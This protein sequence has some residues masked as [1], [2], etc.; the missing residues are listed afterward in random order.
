MSV[1]GTAVLLTTA[2]FAPFIYHNY[3]AYT[4]FCKS[5]TDV[6][7]SWC[8]NALPC[9]YTYSQSRYWNVGFLRY[10]SFSQIPN[11]IVAA[12]LF[13]LIADFVTA[14]AQYH[15]LFSSKN[16]IATDRAPIAFYNI[17]LLPHLIH[18][19]ILFCILLLTAHTQIILRLAPSMPIVFWAAARLIVG[20]AT[21]GQQW[22]TWCTVWGI[23]SIILWASFLPPA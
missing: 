12:P 23:A 1:I 4:V 9:I 15:I 19:V 21:L 2:V 10:W 13:F 7:P 16:R 18:S 11:F 20:R 3:I 14:Y 8:T 22:V 17:S 6:V 5:A